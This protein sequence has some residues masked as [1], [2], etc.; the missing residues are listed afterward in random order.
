M[1]VVA[2]ACVASAADAD[3]YTWVDAKGNV[4]VGNL[5]PPEGARIVGVTRENPEA[6]A[7]AEAARE[8]ARQSEVKA[9]AERVAELESKARAAFDA[10]PAVTY[11]PAPVSY[12][13][14]PQPPQVNVVV[15][16]AAQPDETAS[17]APYGC[18][19]VGCATPWWPYAYPT[20]I[21]VAPSH[22]RHRD[23]HPSHP[24]RMPRVTPPRVA[25]PP[26]KMPVATQL[27]PRGFRG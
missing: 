14:P 1:L 24:I 5:Q 2:A 20:A 3:V 27:A 21:F 18:A 8:A 9:L 19:W 23:F 4:N 12:A 7:Q 11:A 25:A 22:G 17:Y 16:P 6:K 10:P 26:L 15:M 13:P